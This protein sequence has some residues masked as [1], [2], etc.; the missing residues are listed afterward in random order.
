LDQKRFIAF[1]MLSMG[2]LMLSGLL[3]P[4]PEPPK[5]DAP[6]ADGQQPAAEEAEAA[7]ADGKDAQ[8]AEPAADGQ[9]P[10][11]PPAPVADLAV[12]PADTTPLQYVTL[13]SLDFR[14]GYRMLVTLTNQGAAVQRVELSSPRFRDLQDRSGYLGQLALEDADGMGVTVRVVGAGTPA[15]TA[16][17]QPGD[18]IVGIGKSKVAAV[19]TVDELAA[20]LART[21][22]DQEIKLDVKRGEQLV[23]LSAKL[24]WR[25][26]EVI[27]PEIENVLMRGVEPPKDFEG[28]PSFLLTL[29]SYQGQALKDAEAARVAAWLRDGHWE[30]VQHDETS[31]TFRR[32]L[33][34]WNLE[35]LKRFT[36]R[37]VPA[38]SLDDKTYPGYDVT[39]DI[40]LRN[41]GAEPQQVA[42]QLDGPNGMPLEGWWYAHKIGTGWGA[43]GLRDVVV[44]FYEA[45][46]LQI[47]PSKILD[48]G[49]EYKDMGQG[50][51]LA[52]AGVDA[53][54]FSAVLIPQKPLDEVWFDTTEAILVGPMPDAR[55]PKYFANVTCRLNRKSINLE[56]GG[57]RKDSFD[58]FLGPKRPDLLQQYQAGD[59]S[60]YSL[61]DLIYYGWFGP[62]A[63]VMLVVLHFFYSIIGNYGI[64]IILLTVLVRGAMFPIS[65]KQ[66]K[67]MAR[68][69]ALKPDLDR[70]TE[71]YKTDM[72]KRQQATQELYRKNKINPLG[73]CL[74]LFIQMPIFIGLYRSLMIDVE[75][76]QS[77]LFGDW[78]RWCSDLAAPDM[79][80]NWSRI[81][82]QFVNDGIGIFGLGPYL[83]VLPLV[84]VAMFLVTQ[85]MAMPAPANEQAAM[86]QKMMKYMTMFM[87]ILFYKVA[88]GLCL[89]FIAS[90]LWGIGERKLLP[91]PK[92]D[93]DESAV[94]ASAAK[95]DKPSGG[96]G[97]NG[98]PAKRKSKGK[99]KR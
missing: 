94:S 19:N 55:T 93:G 66:T 88:C 6:A 37:A 68:M 28:P 49:D 41:T 96:A 91:K 5:P 71:K 63:R 9:P 48:D 39:M 89:Y 30:V 92:T 65:Y 47:N 81:M 62:V 50:H 21:R 25:P 43:A 84:T 4:Q 3:F 64:A 51:P 86:Q 2:V 26:L 36:I 7:E 14:S 80:L 56:A 27:R 59:D 38:S 72:Q 1:L 46:W 13:G 95:P 10:A 52:Y 82:P 31:V 99:K 44:R 24:G 32:A 53:Q 15:A 90:S 54:Y 29:A 98:S 77:A 69:Q 12:P 97:Q 33:P 60:K 45:S 23:Q 17:L 67:N 83:N 70:I 11:V 79:F 40:E 8:P 57:T 18:V 76:R 73:G 42:Y 22:P 35:L 34:T 16:G 74:P 75:L 85:R 78:T 61:K 58:V 87:A 20:V